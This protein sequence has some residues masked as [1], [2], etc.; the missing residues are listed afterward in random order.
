VW[1]LPGSAGKSFTV[2]ATNPVNITIGDGTGTGT[3]T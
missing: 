1:A 3:I 2:Q